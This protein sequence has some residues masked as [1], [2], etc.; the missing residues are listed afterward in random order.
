MLY[1]SS[2]WDDV[3]EN[4]LISGVESIEECYKLCLITN[5]DYCFVLRYGGN[6]GNQESC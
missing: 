3:R 6:Y 2:T 5:G 1:L 4:L